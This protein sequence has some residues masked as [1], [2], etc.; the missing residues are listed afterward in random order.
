MIIICFLILARI[1]RYID[2]LFVHQ[3]NTGFDGVPPSV[4]LARQIKKPTE[5]SRFFNLA[6]AGR[7]L[8]PL[9]RRQPG[10][11]LS[12]PCLASLASKATEVPMQCIEYLIVII[13]HFHLSK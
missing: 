1:I 6:F 5:R 12:F 11:C 10:G 4:A 7:G 8:E 3:Q 9:G 2:Q 13:V